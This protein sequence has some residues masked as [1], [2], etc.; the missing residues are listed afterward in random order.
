MQE[1]VDP[2]LRLAMI[3]EHYRNPRWRGALADADV[4][5][6]GGNP[7]CGDV[8][9]VYLKVDGDGLADVRFEGRG[10]TV[11]QAGTSMLL[12]DVR[13]RDLSLAAILELDHHHMETLLGSDVVRARPRCAT[14]GLAT[15]KGAVQAYLRRQ[16]ALQA[17]VQVPP[18]TLPP[19]ARGLVLGD[20]VWQAI[21][22]NPAHGDQPPD[23]AKPPTGGTAG[24]GE[25]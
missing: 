18:A 21:G 9:V 3:G 5:M 11:S 23:A 10:C 6:P 12:E 1:G 8:V 22:D 17:G 2:Q 7:G 19:E 15:L 14:L 16:Q 4:V 24:A 20:D 13:A 25:R